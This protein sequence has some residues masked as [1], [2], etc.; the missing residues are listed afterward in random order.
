MEK[1]Q[2]KQTVSKSTLKVKKILHTLG[3]YTIFKREW[4]SLLVIAICSEIK[5][6]SYRPGAQEVAL[7]G[8]HIIEMTE[9]DILSKSGVA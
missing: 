8:T 5:I 9:K 4:P 3:P 1:Q 2:P 6:I 7:H